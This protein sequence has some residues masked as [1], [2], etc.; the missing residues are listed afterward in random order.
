[1]YN[2]FV[3]L[4]VYFAFCSIAGTS[5]A[6]TESIDAMRLLLQKVTQGQEDFFPMRK[7]KV[8]KV[9]LPTEF[10]SESF[11]QTFG[12]PGV[13]NPGLDSLHGV[14]QAIHRALLLKALSTKASVAFM[15]DNYQ[16]RGDTHERTSNRFEEVFEFKTALCFTFGAVLDSIMVQKLSSGEYLVWI[17]N[18]YF[19]SL[20][21][22]LIPLDSLYF[23]ARI[24]HVET[25]PDFS[26]HTY[27][28]D[29]S[30][31]SFG[32]PDDL[33]VMDKLEFAWDSKGKLF[34]G[35]IKDSTVAGDSL[36]FYYLSPN[37]CNRDDSSCIGVPSNKGL[38]PALINSLLWNMSS[39]V[40]EGDAH[41]LSVDELHNS[42]FTK[43]NR[44]LRIA[45][46]GYRPKVI[47]SKG[48]KLY[49]DIDSQ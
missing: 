49:V 3:K 17:N 14:Q 34:W 46:L 35:S 32:S 9:L 42:S 29:L 33:T 22:N 28:T 20:N 48:N 39:F 44:T 23:N 25:K 27:F 10:E 19:K 41:V 15:N 18:T 26:Q 4:V 45:Q 6:Q 31:Q 24:Y 1:M 13:S 11:I 40:L 38:W 16:M 21:D 2:L 5:M 12:F 8:L 30:S 36:M 43:L 7:P 47:Y 37:D